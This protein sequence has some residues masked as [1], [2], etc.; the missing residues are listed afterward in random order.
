MMPRIET[1]YA[2]RECGSCY[3]KWKD[4]EICE[5]ACKGMEK[6]KENLSQAFDLFIENSPFLKPEVK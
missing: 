5:T 1:T 2:C 4:A 3:N 6:V